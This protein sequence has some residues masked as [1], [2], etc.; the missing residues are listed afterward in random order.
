MCPNHARQRSLECLAV[1]LL[2][3]VGMPM[4]EGH[5][6][7]AFTTYRSHQP[8]LPVSFEY[9]TGWDAEMS[10]GKTEAYT[11]V[12]L[13][14]PAAVEQRLRVYLVVRAM[15]LKASGG[16]YASLDEAVA[17]YRET[18]LRTLHITEE[19]QTTVAGVAARQLAINGTLSLPW[20]S[21]TAHAVPVVGGRLFFEKDGRVYECAWLGT[22]ELAAQVQTYFDHVLQTLM[23]ASSS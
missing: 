20:M 6:T 3:T 19:R 15:P 8:Q 1:A 18:L 10:A 17:A 2:V 9:P 12:Q 7:S 14:A 11:Q 23:I 13:Y 22:P 4:G 16:R 5:A 21:A